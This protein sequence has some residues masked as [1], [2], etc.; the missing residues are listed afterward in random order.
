MDISMTYD[1][2]VDTTLYRPEPIPE[3]VPP[4]HQLRQEPIPAAPPVPRPEVE[5]APSPQPQPSPQSTP[6]QAQIQPVPQPTP[7]RVAP[8]QVDNVQ[9][10]NTP[11][12]KAIQ[13]PQPTLQDAAANVPSVS[14]EPS[15]TPQKVK[16][17]EE[18]QAL[19][20]KRQMTAAAVPAPSDLNLHETPVPSVSVSPVA[21]SGL[22]PNPASRLAA[23]GGTPSAGGAAAPGGQA[24]TGLKGR[25]SA[26]QAL[27]NHEDCVSRQT[28]GK[29][30]PPS[31]KMKDYASMQSVGPRP[32]A[33]FQAA[34]A[35]RDARRKYK[36]DPG[37][38]DYWNRVG[39]NPSTFKPSENDHP[40]PGAYDSAKDQRVMTH[41]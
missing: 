30:I 23:G 10:I 12:A 9:A 8:R 29:P 16:K 24:G 22:T 37:N 33:D 19:D 2:P 32:D 17:K 6:Q 14:D 27:Q 18:E 31:C 5:P 20:A 13:Q 7:Q 21:P 1:S 4:L 34:A 35:Q 36:T 3:P 11:T 26:T 38:A 15:P 28:E 39:H 25:G 40:T 41:Q